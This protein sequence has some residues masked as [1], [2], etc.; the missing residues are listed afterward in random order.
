MTTAHPRLDPIVVGTQVGM[1]V[2]LGGLLCFV[3][4]GALVTGADRAIAVAVT[5]AGIGCAYLVAVG[6]H[7]LGT[8]PLRR[9]LELGGLAAMIVGTL[10]LAW[11]TPYGAYVLF[12]LAY[13]TLELV[14]AGI[15][16]A[17]VLGTTL[18]AV[19][20]LNARTGWS[21]FGV[22]GPLLSA[23]VALVMGLSFQAM[24][25]Q[26]AERERLYRDLVAVQDQLAATER[27]AGAMAE[28]ARL[29]REIHDTV[30][31]GLSS[32]TLL[33]HAVERADPARPGIEELR[34]AR[35]TAATG[36]AET[37]RFIRELAPPLLDEES[38][39]GALRRLAAGSWSRPGLAV[40]VRV[41][42][43]LD[44]PMSVQTALLRVAQGAMANVLA[45][46]G[47]SH[48]TIEVVTGG[49]AVTLTVADD[50][51]GM[52]PEAAWRAPGGPRGDSFG[53]RAIRERAEQLGGSMTLESEPGHGTT[54]RVSLPVGAA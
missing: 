52:D 1:Q 51:V 16:S 44:L 22:V 19:L 23:A 46:A 5:A 13:I 30:A 39:G 17:V 12:P 36:L 48:A 50:G 11:L 27:E 49:P 2:L 54:V 18:A 53:L 4:V 20:L 24:R 38:L 3:G 42:D 43:A 37:R 40:D 14:S 7:G 34:L 29:A 45:H 9:R 32:I 8:R 6:A 21:P 41:A 31:Q 26:S 33:L 35:E 47:A 25:R 10:A 28:R 15:G